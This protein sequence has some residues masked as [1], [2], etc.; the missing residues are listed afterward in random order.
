MD[1]FYNDNI[2]DKHFNDENKK[3]DSDD[4]Y[5]LVT[6]IDPKYGIIPSDENIN[7]ISTRLYQL[8]NLLSKALQSY[9]LNDKSKLDNN[10]LVDITDYKWK[11][12]CDEI[13]KNNSFISIFNTE[14]E[15]L[16]SNSNKRY[17]LVKDTN[18]RYI[19]IQV[20]GFIGS[21]PGA[22]T[23]TKMLDLVQFMLDIAGFIPGAGIAIDIVG[24]ILSLLRGDFMGA[25]FS[26]INV[27]PLVG[28]FVGT[29]L[30]YIKKFRKYSGASKSRKS[31]RRSPRKSPRKSP[32]RRS[33]RKKSNRYSKENMEKY[34]NNAQDAMDMYDQ[35][36]QEE[37]YDEDYDYDEN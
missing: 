22:S 30:K 10:G 24:T 33:P 18:D 11:E 28:S 3:Y 8:N 4:V 17:T 19:P 31:P 5:R 20:G 9:I 37:D 21:E 29:P 1:L 13:D 16:C 25:M 12:I 36:S 32:R 35:Y 7:L 27:I 26:A 14:G 15:K 2:V 6:L 34:A 23:F